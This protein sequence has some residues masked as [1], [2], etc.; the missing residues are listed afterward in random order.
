MDV[1]RKQRLCYHVVFLPFA[2][3]LAVSAHVISSIRLFP[4][5]NKSPNLMKKSDINPMPQ[6]FDRFINTVAD[7]ELSHAFDDS[8]S[9]LDQLDKTLLTKLGGKT[10]APGKWTAKG[11][12][13]HVTDFERIFAY[14]VLLDN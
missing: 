8:I 1:R 14:R 11:I 4:D 6:Y 5:K 12:I 2:C 10:Y 9:Q 13:Q 3:V 7:V